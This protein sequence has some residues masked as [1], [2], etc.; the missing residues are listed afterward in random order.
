MNML[1]APPPLAD[2]ERLQDAI[3]R[4]PMASA[5]APDGVITMGILSRPIDRRASHRRP[6]D[7]VPE[8]TAVRVRSEE[9]EVINL[10]CGGMLFECAFR[11]PPGT[12]S[13][14]E[15]LRMDA[16]LRVRGHVLRSQVSA[17][18]PKGLRY[19]IAIAFNTPLDWIDDEDRLR[20]TVRRRRP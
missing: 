12:E 5:Q 18:S 17:L 14:L 2:S 20:H 4:P 3:E 19:R 13:R 11:L 8:V 6:L 9:V 16:P 7:Q 10:S 15:I 1:E